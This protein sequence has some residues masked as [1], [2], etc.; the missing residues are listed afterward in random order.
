[1]LAENA[2]AILMFAG[3]AL[4][5][6]ILMRR[7][8]TAWLRPG[9]RS[10]E[11]KEIERLHAPRSRDSALGDA[12]VDLLRWQVEMHETARDLKAEIDSKLAALQAL[13]ILARQESERLQAAIQRAEKAGTAFPGE[14]ERDVLGMIERLADP[15]ALDD[16]TQ[17]AELAARL[18]PL[19]GGAAA[20]LFDDNERTIAIARLADQ[21]QSPAEIARRLGLAVGDVE[22]LLS[23]RSA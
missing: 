12:P 23:L 20:D 11:P 15:A 9:G 6:F 21:G 18:P 3:M 4:A 7:S 19:P 10:A 5:I 1:M 14:E 13:V 17:L 2:S 8:A 16:P 22:L